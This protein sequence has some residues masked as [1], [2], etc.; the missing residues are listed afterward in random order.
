MDWNEDG[1]KDLITGE[2]HGYIRI[3]LNVNTDADPKFNGYSYLKEGAYPY[4]GGYIYS[5]PYVVDW[6]NDGKK[7]VLCGDGGGGVHLLLNEGTNAGPRFNKATPLTEGPQNDPIECSSHS[8]PVAAD[9]NHDGKKDLLLGGYKGDIWFYENQGSDANP[10]FDR[11]VQLEAGGAAIDVGK[12]ARIEVVDWNGDGTLDLISGFED[13][14]GHDGAVWL[15]EHVG[16]LWLDGNSI[17][18]GAGGAVKMTLDA[19]NSQAG[20][21]YLIVGGMSGN[22]PGTPLPGG[23]AVLP[24]NWDAFTNLMLVSLNTPVFDNFTG[25]L[26]VKGQGLATLNAAPAPGALGIVMCYAYALSQPWDFASNGVR[27]EFTP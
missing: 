15:F 1:K 19:G 5:T 17:S 9:F 26:D 6:N 25:Q 16:P 11:G 13:G 21:T 7:D 27:I 20:R 14:L 18:T 10:Y 22:S 3:F 8:S 12:Y 2:S 24:V 23:Q 4:V